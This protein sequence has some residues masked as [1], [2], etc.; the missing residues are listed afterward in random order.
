MRV[1]DPSGP[2]KVHVLDTAVPRGS[3]APTVMAYGSGRTKATV[4]FTR[5]RMELQGAHFGPVKSSPVSRVHG[6]A[7]GKTAHGLRAAVEAAAE[8]SADL[9]A[10]AKMRMVLGAARELTLMPLAPV[11]AQL[12]SCRWD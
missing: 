10:A 2:G 4:E 7:S 9:D 3:W 5:V 6:G 12:E 11:N 1:L 8:S